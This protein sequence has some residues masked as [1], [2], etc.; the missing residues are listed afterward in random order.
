[1]GAM[2]RARF[3]KLLAG[4][5]FHHEGPGNVDHVAYSLGVNPGRRIVV[6][7]VRTSGVHAC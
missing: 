2:E 1:M 7:A 5:P 6:T 4:A 3:L